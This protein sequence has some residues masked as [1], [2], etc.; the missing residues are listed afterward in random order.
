MGNIESM[1]KGMERVERMVHNK[2]SLLCTQIL[3]DLLNQIELEPWLDANSTDPLEF[4]DLQTFWTACLGIQCSK[5]HYYSYVPYVDPYHLLS[6]IQSVC[7][8]YLY[9]LVYSSVDF[10]DIPSVHLT[11]YWGV[12]PLL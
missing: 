8:W 10:V 11:T 7:H 2:Y 1:V 12:S 4:V 3:T 6:I 5:S 9:L